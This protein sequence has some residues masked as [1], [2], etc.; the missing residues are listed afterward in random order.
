MKTARTGS[1]ISG[2]LATLSASFVTLAAQAHPGHSLGDAGAAH[3]VT[4]PY[5]L[6]TLA[7][8]GAV[9]WIVGSRLQRPRPAQW[10]RAGGA[11][12]V[13]VAG[14]WTGCSL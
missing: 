3:M 2:F 5:H 6:S 1:R 9:L 13:V 12:L 4:S 11:L 14:V 10:L 8:T 7:A